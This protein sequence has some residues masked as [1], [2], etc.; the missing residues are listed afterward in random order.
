MP[1]AE[2]EPYGHDLDMGRALRHGLGGDGA[3]RFVALSCPPAGR[4]RRLLGPRRGARSFINVVGVY[5][6]SPAHAGALRRHS[7]ERDCSANASTV[8]AVLAT[9]PRSRT[10]APRRAPTSCRWADMFVHPPR[11]STRTSAPG[12][13]QRRTYVLDARRSTASSSTNRW[14]GEST[15][16]TL[17]RCSTPPWP[18][19]ET[20]AIGMCRRMRRARC[21]PTPSSRRSP[22]VG[23]GRRERRTWATCSTTRPGLRPGPAGA[24]A[25]KPRRAPTDQASRT[26][27]VVQ[28]GHRPIR[29]TT[30][31][32][33]SRH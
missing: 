23:Q 19:T 4:G 14:L 16:K 31:T 17:S 10:S 33:R 25:T 21:S 7:D 8:P 13:R 6:A 5:E 18:L 3:G 28:T 9:A 2:F 27:G 22:V 12:R 1:D 26:R 29:P 20:S 30:W 11:P 32:H 24:S 15:V